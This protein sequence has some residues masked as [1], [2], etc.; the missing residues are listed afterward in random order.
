MS[1]RG[2][3]SMNRYVPLPALLLLLTGRVGL[4]V[5]D[6]VRAG[7]RV[8]VF[9]T[10]TL[11]PPPLPPL[12]FCAFGALCLAMIEYLKLSNVAQSA[13]LQNKLVRVLATFG[14][15]LQLERLVNLVRAQ[16]AH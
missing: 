11:L 6:L 15:S 14:G 4:R 16:F 10:L 9:D 5:R 13:R 2:G 7:A 3:A 8:L 1:L 12:R